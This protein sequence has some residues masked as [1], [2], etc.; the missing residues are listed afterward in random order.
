M[1]D[2][3]KLPIPDQ[4][5]VT[6]PAAGSDWSFTN[7][8]GGLLLV[9]AA[10]F[11]LT[12]S[13]AVANRVVALQVAN[14][15]R[16]YLRTSNGQAQAASLARIY[17]AFAPVASAA[18]NAGVDLIPWRNDG[19]LLGRGHKLSSVTALIDVA[20][21]YTAIV[22]DVL[23]YLPSYDGPQQPMPGPYTIL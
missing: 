16:V 19:V 5:V 8:D 15:S 4:I 22:L 10:T 21:A 2:S 23:R 7:S 18:D 14:D 17:C 11:T 9:R 3:D 13:A 1:T 20:D 6:P 12:T